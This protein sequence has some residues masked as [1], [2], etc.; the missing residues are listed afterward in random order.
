M[1][2]YNQLPVSTNA[3]LIRYKNL[4][5]YKKS[6]WETCCHLADRDRLTAL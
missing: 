3:L 5:N 4:T 2:G 6:R 1:T